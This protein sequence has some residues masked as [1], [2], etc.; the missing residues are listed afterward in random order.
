MNANP[1]YNINQAQ[2][3]P[4]LQRLVQILVQ[5]PQAAA[6][7]DAQV[8][9]TLANLLPPTPQYTCPTCREPVRTRPIEVFAMKAIVRVVAA[10][11]GE[12]SPKKTVNKNWKEKAGPWDK[13]FPPKNT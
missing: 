9:A 1:H 10:A 12:S 5:N 4:H 2:H 13:F 3:I 6:H 11:A 8:A 7:H